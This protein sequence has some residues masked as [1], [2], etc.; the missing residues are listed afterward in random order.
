MARYPEIEGKTAAVT[1][2]GRSIGRAIALRLAREGAQVA[3]ADI[4]R[5]GAESVAAEIRVLWW[6][7]PRTSGGRDLFRRRRRH[8][9]YDGGNLRQA[10]H[11]G[12]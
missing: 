5:D 4:D 7:C 6:Q 10:G 3:V 8:G 2:G 12:G 11:S 9:R 1:G